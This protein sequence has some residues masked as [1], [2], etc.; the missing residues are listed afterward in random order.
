VF[1]IVAA[2]VGQLAA[3]ERQQAHEAHQ[4]ADEQE[5]LYRLTRAFNQLTTDEGV[6]QALVNTLKRDLKA[7]EAYV[8]PYTADRPVTD[9]DTTIHYV[10]LQ[11][12]NHVFG[13][14]CVAFDSAYHREKT[15]LLNTC[16]SQAAMALHR[17]DLAE[18]ARKSQQFEEA[19]RLKTA[20]LHAVSH[21]LRTPITI[22]KTS[23]SN[24][25]TLDGRLT[26]AERHE[27]S[28]SI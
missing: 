9:T 3:R 15:R 20:L 23:A 8:L 10:L 12:D 24:L 13:T 2:L 16:T 4:R 27:F 21:D 1:F 11:V 25:R 6:Y 26:P 18:R 28:E 19:D 17:I 5:I 14:L 22:I 7:R